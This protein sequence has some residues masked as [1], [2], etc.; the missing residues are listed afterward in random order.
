MSCIK[1]PKRIRSQLLAKLKLESSIIGFA[2]NRKYTKL[3]ISNKIGVYSELPQILVGFFSTQQL[4]GWKEKCACLPQSNYLASTLG[5]Q[6][7]G[8]KWFNNFLCFSLVSMGFSFTFDGDN[9]NRRLRQDFPCGNIFGGGLPGY[10]K[11]RP[12]R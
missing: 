4:D 6:V 11:S 5:R 7:E 10:C 3:L 8:Y 12:Q 1:L 9:L 2:M